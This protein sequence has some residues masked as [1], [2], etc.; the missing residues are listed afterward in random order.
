[1]K[2]LIQTV[3]AVLIAS[4]AALAQNSGKTDITGVIRDASDGSP[5]AGA[6]VLT[7]GQ[8]GSFISGTTTDAKGEFILKINPKTETMIQASF[9]GY[10]AVAQPIENRTRIE[11]TLEP[12][13][14]MIEK[15]VV[16][17]A[18]WTEAS[19]FLTTTLAWKSTPNL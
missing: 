8:T 6:T 4:F 11:I 17:R 12:T 18:V 5:I 9:L 13:S 1:M 16:M 10:A 19:S 2:R 15:S 3:A 14:E 7:K